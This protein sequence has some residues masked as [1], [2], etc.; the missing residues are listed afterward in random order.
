ML[1]SNGLELSCLANWSMSWHSLR[2]C[3]VV[4]IAPIL[5]R[6]Q[7]VYDN[8]NN[9]IISHTRFFRKCKREFLK[10]AFA[11]INKCKSI[12]TVICIWR[13]DFLF[14]SCSHQVLLHLLHWLLYFISFVF[15]PRLQLSGRE[16]SVE[17]DT[18]E[19]NGRCNN[20]NCLPLVFRILLTEG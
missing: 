7:R 16:H 12:D 1:L 6:L 2:S 17:C 4:A 9:K 15:G 8:I 19:M 14:L 10:M 5:R 20:E 11:R 13:V 18:H 3:I